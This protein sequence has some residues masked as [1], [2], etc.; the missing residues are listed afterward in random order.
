MTTRPQHQEAKMSTAEALVQT[1]TPAGSHSTTYT[2]ADLG[3]VTA[4]IEPGTDATW[5]ALLY[6]GPESHEYDTAPARSREEA[7][8]IAVGHSYRGFQPE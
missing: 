4:V 1:H 6:Y 7:D 5:A 8:T 3:I 2:R